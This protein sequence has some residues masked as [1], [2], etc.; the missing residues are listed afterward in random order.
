MF[1]FENQ[2]SGTLFLKIFAPA[3]PEKMDFLYGNHNKLVH[4]FLISRLW[5]A[6]RQL[7]GRE[8]GALGQKGRVFAVMFT[9]IIWYIISKIFAPAAPT[10]MDFLHGNHSKLFNI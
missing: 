2:Y 3:A 7:E 6:T 4:I 9:Y 1:T 8:G 10:K 5:P